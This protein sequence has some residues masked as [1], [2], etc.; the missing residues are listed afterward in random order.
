MK[1]TV[2]VIIDTHN[3]KHRCRRAFKWESP[4]EPCADSITFQLIQLERLMASRPVAALGKTDAHH[5]LLYGLSGL[6]TKA[7]FTLQIQ[8]RSSNCTLVASCL[9]F[10]FR[11]FLADKGLAAMHL[12]GFFV[13]LFLGFFPFL[14][15][16]V[17]DTC[18][19]VLPFYLSG[20]WNR[21][22]AFHLGL[23]H[24]EK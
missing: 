10:S 8:G 14:F 16:S 1:W 23:K 6:N 9:M 11:S 3:R 21:L 19:S 18:M 5:F 17:P 20:G 7:G 22:M 12:L 24:F 15:T 13:S 2:S 4:P